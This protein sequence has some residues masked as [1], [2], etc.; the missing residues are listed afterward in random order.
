MLGNKCLIM[1][2]PY[3]NTTSV[4]ERDREGGRNVGKK[5]K[6]EKKIFS[7]ACRE[8]NGI[9]V[10]SDGD[11]DDTCLNYFGTLDQKRRGKKYRKFKSKP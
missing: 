9:V 7:R 1:H 11:C 6:T 3:N 10:Q 8:S 5:K 2:R 4:H